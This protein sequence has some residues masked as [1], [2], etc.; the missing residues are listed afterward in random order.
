[1]C[2]GGSAAPT[3]KPPEQKVIE[4]GPESPNDKVNNM[5]VENIND[6]S[7]QDMFR[8]K[9]RGATATAQTSKGYGGKVAIERTWD[10]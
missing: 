10:D 8:S 9:N 3:W 1:M 5:E 7:Q 6:R 4:P 2:L